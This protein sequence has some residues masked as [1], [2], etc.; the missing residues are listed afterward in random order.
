MNL[1][2][3]VVAQVDQYL[4][5]LRLSGNYKERQKI[6]LTNQQ[7][8]VF[9]GEARQ[10]VLNAVMRGIIADEFLK[11]VEAERPTPGTPLPEQFT[12]FIAKELEGK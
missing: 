3:V 6:K 5:V 1:T 4:M 7:L 2:D 11:A 12:A 9:C 8:P 10:Y